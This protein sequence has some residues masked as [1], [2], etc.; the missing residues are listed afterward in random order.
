MRARFFL[1]LSLT[2]AGAIAQTETA[3]QRG[4]RVVDE[5]L[6]ALGGTRYLAM[7]D[8]LET[9]RAYSFY[10]EELQGLS[11]AKIYSRYLTRP[12]PPVAGF[13]GIREREVFGKS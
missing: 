7:D 2:C 9:G 5:A 6:K 4:K 8:R 11:R 10:R 3:Q 1:L 12:E 13:F